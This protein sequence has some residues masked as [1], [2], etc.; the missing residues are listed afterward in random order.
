MQ[1]YRVIQQPGGSSLPATMP[2]PQGSGMAVPATMPVLAGSG[3]FPHAGGSGSFPHSGHPQRVVLPASAPV[4]QP[5]GTRI[6]HYSL[7]PN[8]SPPKPGV[9]GS[10]PTHYSSPPSTGSSLTSSYRKVDGNLQVPASI[11]RIASARSA[12][13]TEPIRTTTTESNASGSLDQTAPLDQSAL[14]DQTT[15]ES[16][17]STLLESDTT[18]T[19]LDESVDAGQKVDVANDSS[20]CTK[21]QEDAAGVQPVSEP[22]VQQA[23]ENDE[24]N[25]FEALIRR[26]CLGSGSRKVNA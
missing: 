2:L 7:S 23:T 16:H 4:L 1:S 6:A 5:A 24:V 11:L 12:S 17:R 9:V 8:S 3:S 21:K 15:L 26:P 22:S 10:T 19:L 14:A 13:T 18:T 20:T 25:C